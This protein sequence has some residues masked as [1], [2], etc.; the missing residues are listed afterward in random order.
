MSDDVLAQ[1]FSLA[2][3]FDTRKLRR[4]L[5]R[6]LVKPATPAAPAQIEQSPRRKASTASAVSALSA[7]SASEQ[8]AREAKQELMRVD[9]EWEKHFQ[10]LL[11]EKEALQ[12]KLQNS[13]AKRSALEAENASLKITA[14]QLDSYKV[15]SDG[16]L[17]LETKVARL[18]E[19]ARRSAEDRREANQRLASF[20]EEKSQ[21]ASELKQVTQRLR[22]KEEEIKSLAQTLTDM[23]LNEELVKTKAE[24]VEQERLRAERKFENKELE[25]VQIQKDLHGAQAKLRTQQLEYETREEKMRE[26]YE[27]ALDEKEECE[28]K[29]KEHELKVFLLEE[30]LR[31]DG[32]MPLTHLPEALTPDNSE[33][34]D[35]LRKNLKKVTAVR[36]SAMQRADT[37]E[38]EVLRLENEL[39]QMQASARGDPSEMSKL[40]QKLQKT[41][42]E[43]DKLRQEKVRTAYCNAMAPTVKRQ[44]PGREGVLHRWG[45]ICSRDFV[46]RKFFLTS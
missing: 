25:C 16:K 2:D 9:G 45:R 14:T 40:S 43:M 20:A 13:E 28:I 42:T 7:G 41:A 37:A 18:E 30:Q 21:R 4:G 10:A 46:F 35:A 12:A 33:E 36:N 22:E 15:M 26:M 44:N 32:Q 24:T 38:N 27:D 19:D 29:T 23:K 1:K 3:E 11:Q 8:V 31:A 5:S 6:A 17:Q 34:M 39:K